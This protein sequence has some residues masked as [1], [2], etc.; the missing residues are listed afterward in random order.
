MEPP[1]F[2]GDLAGTPSLE[3]D[4]LVLSTIHS[5]KGLEWDAVTLL[6]AA[7]GCIPSDLATGDDEELEEERRL[8]YVALTRARRHLT[9]TSPLRF[10]V[11]E[12][13]PSDTHLTAPLSR[14][15]QPEQVQ[16]CL[17]V[18]A[19]PAGGAPDLPPASPRLADAVRARSRSR[20]E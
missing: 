18:V 2:S 7:D 19:T 14:F 6:H 8:L 13:Q 4:W 10:H 20:W 12:R 16:A 11:R 15:L 9:V 17:D 5:A 3:E 1:T